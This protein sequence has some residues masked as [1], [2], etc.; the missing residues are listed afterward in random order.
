MRQRE[1]KRYRREIARGR[2]SGHFASYRG[3]NDDALGRAVGVAA[4]D[5]EELLRSNVC[6]KPCLRH[7]VPVFAHLSVVFT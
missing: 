1:S 6:P 2:A 4:L 3:D 5:V 7:A